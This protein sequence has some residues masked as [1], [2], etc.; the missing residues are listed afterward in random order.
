MQDKSAEPSRDR[1][2]KESVAHPASE[3][4][5]A[6]RRQAKDH[7]RAAARLRK[8]AEGLAAEVA[9]SNSAADQCERGAD[10]LQ[11]ETKISGDES[12]PL[13]NPMSVVLLRLMVAGHRKRAEEAVRQGDDAERAAQVQESAAAGLERDAN[14]LM[15]SGFGAVM[16]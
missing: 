2:V 11:P 6:L 3:V 1:L 12:E 8:L 15:R 4:I 14:R 7:R 10:L 9:R 5:G 16:Q 13:P